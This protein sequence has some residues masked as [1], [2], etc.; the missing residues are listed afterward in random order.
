MHRKLF[1]SMAVAVV[2]AAAQAPAA[3]FAPVASGAVIPL[4]SNPLT[5][6]AERG[7]IA[8]GAGREC[9]RSG[10]RVAM[11]L[12]VGAGTTACAL[13]PPVVGRDLDVS[14]TGRLL[15]GTPAK[16]RARAYLSAAL[17]VGE[18][19]NLHV[20]VFP[21]QKKLQVVKERPDGEPRYLEVVKRH[22]AIQ[23]VNKANRIYLR[24]VNAGPR[25]N[26]RIVVRV[27]G[28]RLAVLDDRRC[29]ELPGRDVAFGVGS[30]PGGAG[31]VGS[32]A[33]LRIA[34]PSPF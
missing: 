3:I 31:V 4:Y 25:G 10:T 9:K 14:V 13:M 18:G 12:Q 23:G 29:A 7:Q 11:R 8:N 1:I 21:V 27:N 19:G 26:C 33:K 22:D 15:S 24:A 32:F 6:A 20:R 16:L 28:K 17:R 5:S 30:P 34:M 2:A